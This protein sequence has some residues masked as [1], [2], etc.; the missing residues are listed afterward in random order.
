MDCG[1]GRRG[2]GQAAQVEQRF[3]Q[4]HARHQVARTQAQRRSAACQ[5]G[6]EATALL[7]D[8][9]GDR[10]QHEVAGVQAQRLIEDA[11][12][13]GPVRPPLNGSKDAWVG[14]ARLVDPDLTIDDADAMTRNDL[15]E[16]YGDR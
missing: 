13:D 15:I 1:N 8:E 9:A 7:V 2:V 14:Y 6:L 3:A 11:E 5:R 4:L 16:K 10:L 12:D